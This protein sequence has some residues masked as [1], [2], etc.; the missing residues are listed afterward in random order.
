MSTIFH[1][2]TNIGLNRG[3]LTKA[4]Y[5]RVNLF[6]QKH[7]SYLLTLHYQTNFHHIVNTIKN[8]GSL[9]ENV[10]IS[11][12]FDWILGGDLYQDKIIPLSSKLESFI[13]STSNQIIKKNGVNSIRVYENGLFV[14][15]VKFNENDI[16]E[17]VD[18]MDPFHRT[19]RD[20]YDQ[21]GYLRRTRHF[22]VKTG[23]VCYEQYFDTNGFCRLAIWLKSNEIPVR[24]VRFSNKGKGIT[25]NN[26]LSGILTEWFSELMPVDSC[27]FFDEHTTMRYAESI[28][29]SVRKFAF[30]HTN[31]YAN[32][33]DMSDGVCRGVSPVFDN[34]DEFVKII[35]LTK[36]QL[37]EVITSEYIKIDDSNSYVISHYVQPYNKQAPRNPLKIVTV[38]R[39]VEGKKIELAIQAFSIVAKKYNSAMFEIYGS[40]P[41]GEKLNVLINELELQE[42][43]KIMGYTA[44]SFAVFSE[45][46]MSVNPSQH[47][48][49]GLSMLESLAAGC[50]V[51]AFDIKFGPRDMVV[52][53]KN[54]YLVN[55]GDI[56]GMADAMIKCLEHS[57][58][59][60]M[61]RHAVESANLFSLEN[62]ARSLSELTGLD[63][64]P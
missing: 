23:D 49:F 55:Y 64:M 40:G 31:H 4:V 42:N 36:Q 57:A 62:Y 47:E 15:Y 46:A 20:E 35:F 24:Y 6:A 5:Q 22:D 30:V 12:L 29:S 52:N 21:F 48:G 9:H 50:P 27:A 56:N 2:L 17:F 63:L 3:G 43:V 7:D 26:T 14:K 44:D 53:D 37:H 39:L 60:D 34:S 19:K 1:L 54:G 59:G 45:A 18:H 13:I 33:K 38:T 32:K 41:E 51:I 16:V 10:K 11:N 28:P 8:N 58:S 25:E 61:N